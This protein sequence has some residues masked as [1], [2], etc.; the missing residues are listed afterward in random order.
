MKQRKKEPESQRSNGLK[1][2]IKKS[3]AEAGA[4]VE[5]N[6]IKSVTRGR[7]KAVL[8]VWGRELEIVSKQVMVGM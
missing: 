1:F 6:V 3:T 8:T 2:D 4:K 7:E 5:K